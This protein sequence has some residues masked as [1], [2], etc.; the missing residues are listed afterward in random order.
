M[1]RPAARRAPSGR[2][3]TRRLQKTLARAL[4]LHGSRAKPDLSADPET[5]AKAAGCRYVD[6]AAPGI[7][8]VRAGKGFRY[9]GPD[10]KAVRDLP[11]L[12]R[13]K[14][15]AIPPAWERVWICPTE[16]G[17]IQATGRD[18]RGRKQYRYHPRF[19]EIREETKYARMIAFAE[20]LPAIRAE[21][22]EHLGRPGLPREKVLATV[23]RLLEITLIRIGNEEYARDNGSFGLTTM[24]AHHVDISGAAIRFQFRGKSGKSHAVKVT[25]RRLARVIA[26]C[27][28]LP[29]EALFQYEAE[30]GELETI[31]ASDVNEYLREISRADFTAKDFRTWAGTVLT[32]HA[33]AK[34]ADGDEGVPLKKNMVAAVKEV[35][36]RLG[37]TPSVCRKCYVH[38]DVFG[39]YLD[40]ELVTSLTRRPERAEDLPALSSEEASVLALLRRKVT[41]RRPPRGSAVEPRTR[42]PRA[43]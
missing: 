32:A 18:A 37:N 39:A 26:R 43:A 27:N 15:L 36:A 3:S 35:C 38:P 14:S 9:L 19:R 28:D 13:I 34:L 40:G 1:A 17:H 16:D 30:D 10:G 22:D 42:E 4:G 2:R 24:R 7:C 21:V 20:A 5:S 23:V 41:I 25:D 6:D 31:E 8:R 29:G 12:K 33:L 11:T